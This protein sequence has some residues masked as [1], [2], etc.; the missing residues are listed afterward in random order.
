MYSKKLTLSLLG[1][2]L[3]SSHSLAKDSP[4]IDDADNTIRHDLVE[5]A[6]KEGE[7]SLPDQ[8]QENNLQEFQLDNNS[9]DFRYFIDSSSLQTSKDGVTRFSLVIRSRSGVDNSSYEGMRCGQREYTVYAYG[10]KQ[11]LKMMP[12]S[13][14]KHIK[15][16]GR[17]NYRH[18]LYNDLICNTNTGKA[19][20][21]E[22]VLHA[23]KNGMKVTIT[24]FL[25]DQE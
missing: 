5:K 18:A 11:G 15:K 25:Q 1:L 16:S 21:L 9:G 19:N 20:R 17:G 10:S 22:D 8:Y 14:W 24:P 3:I 2:L 12:E 13:S 6:W 7:V 23:M 4:F